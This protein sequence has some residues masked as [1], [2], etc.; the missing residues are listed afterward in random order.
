MK[1]NTLKSLLF[2][3][4]LL[5]GVLFFTPSC[6]YDNMEDLNP[7]DTTSVPV[8]DTAGTITFTKH[9]QPV[10][11][12]YCS[13][14]GCHSGNAPSAGLSLVSYEDVKNSAISGKLLGSITWDGSTSQMPKGSSNKISDCNISQVSKW[15]SSNYAQ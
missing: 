4:S 11:T 9:I 3:C 13:V 5:L 14:S 10:M 8:C 15:I 12:N 1:K 6:Y 2:Y 7:K